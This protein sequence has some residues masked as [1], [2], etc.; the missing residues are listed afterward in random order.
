VNLKPC[1]FCGRE[2]AVGTV[3]YGDAMVKDQGWK[4]DTF[5]KV[6]CIYC[7]GNNLGLVGFPTEEAA[8][9]HWN[10]RKETET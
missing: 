6:N 4:Q 2:S 8:I 10:T 5:F 1:P 3:R 9:K 7:G